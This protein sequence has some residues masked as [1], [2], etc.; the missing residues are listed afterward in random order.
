MVRSLVALAFLFA[1]LPAG[2]NASSCAPTIYAPAGTYKTD[3]LK[4]GPGL[5]LSGAGLTGMP[6][7]TVLPWLRSHVEAPS[8][9]RAG[10]LLILKASSGRDYSDMYYRA[11]KLQSIREI[12]IPPCASRSEVNALAQY[13]VRADF[14]LFAGGDQAHYVPWKGSLLMNAV[15][16]V[17]MRG[18]IVGGGSAGL[19]IQGEVVF[20]S[21]A[22]DRVLPDDKDVATPDAVANPYEPAISFTTGLFAWPPLR[23][24]ITDTHFAR[25]DRFGRLA[26]FMARSIRDGLVSG[27][28]M[29]GVAVDEDAA[30][31]VNAQ[32]IATLVQRPREEDGYVPK[33]AYIVYGGPAQRIA[34]GKPLK[35]TVQVTHLTRPGQTY[36][37]VHKR[38]QGTRYTVTVDGS[39]KPVYSRNPYGF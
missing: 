5:V 12:F 38:G 8:G 20:D 10:N 3:H 31:L 29:Y 14:V 36:D 19:A 22:A 24:Y 34:P 27:N 2:A 33:G 25:R 39:K 6:Y 9:A 15:T 16:H 26:A 4:G 11:S 7:E 23:G 28:S 32:G 35:Y 37:L 1:L 30:L 13:A 17:Y 21:A 18:G